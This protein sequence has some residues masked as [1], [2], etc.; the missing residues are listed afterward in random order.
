VGWF[1]EPKTPFAGAISR[2]VSSR[3]TLAEALAATNATESARGRLNVVGS[4][5]ENAA[6]LLDTVHEQAREAFALLYAE[7]E[8]DPVWKVL[9]DPKYIEGSDEAL[10]EAW[11]AAI[12]S[13]PAE[14]Q[15]ERSKRHLRLTYRPTRRLAA[16][17]KSFFIFVRA[18]QDVL[19]CLLNATS[20]GSMEAAIKNVSNPVRIVLDQ[21]LPEYVA[22]FPEFRN[23]RN[24]IKYGFGTALSGMGSPR[25]SGSLGIIVASTPAAVVYHLSDAA[26]GL[27]FS[28]QLSDVTAKELKVRG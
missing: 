11:Q 16:A 20:T 6:E 19:Y 2:F 24:K 28:S 27:E 9:R 1:D 3:Q 8:D 7:Y 21:H 25:G 17:Y 5:V 12:A 18:Y 13:V 26:T 14:A 22:W 4:D 10:A 23:L 15:L